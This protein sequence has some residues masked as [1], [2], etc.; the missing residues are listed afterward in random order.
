MPHS[1]LVQY[2]LRGLD[3]L[4]HISSRPDGMRLNELAA[5][6]GLKKPTLHNLLRTLAAR[7][8]V[9]KDSMNRFNI[10]HAFYEIASSGAFAHKLAKAQNVFI[11]QA[12][13]LPGA[14]ITLTVLPQDRVR[15]LQRVSPDDPGNIQRPEEMI[16][17]PYVMVSSIVLQSAYPEAAARLEE[18][19]P[20]EEYGIG[21]WGSVEKFSAAKQKV[22]QDGFYCR[23]SRGK[24]SLAFVMPE[25]HALG[26]CFPI[27]DKGDIEQYREAALDF[28][29]AVWGE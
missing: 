5:V 17:T 29:H 16:F 8:F 12:E 28:R 9:F 19:Y 1:E 23:V 14:T 7:G 4:R 26:F 25:C 11:D 18:R 2:L 13:K 15:C 21:M 27:E 22:L 24:M 3:I 10:G 20:F 6:T